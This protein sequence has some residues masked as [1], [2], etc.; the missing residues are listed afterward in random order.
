MSPKKRRA[1]KPNPHRVPPANLRWRCDPA[2]FAFTTTA[3]IGKCPI[4]I[5]G[6]GRA[7]EAMHRGLRVQADGY[8]VFVT[9]EVGSGRS[10]VVRRT[11][12]SLERGSESPS[13]LVYVHNFQD[14]DQP[15]LLRFPAGRGK[16][17]PWRAK[18]ECLMVQLF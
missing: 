8:N 11:L 6:Q 17:R 2:H 12:N 18:G 5:I 15:R 1:P 3:E 16:E 10:T 7:L 13:D 14:H 4:N 9:G